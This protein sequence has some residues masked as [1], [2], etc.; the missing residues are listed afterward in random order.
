MEYLKQIIDYLCSQM[1]G[2]VVK[3]ANASSGKGKE[4]SVQKRFRKCAEKIFSTLIAYPTFG[5]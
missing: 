4:I 1:A 5:R 3:K 2:E